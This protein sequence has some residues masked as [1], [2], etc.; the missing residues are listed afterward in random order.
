ME[1]QVFEFVKLGFKET[2][3]LLNKSLAE[4][5]RLQQKQQL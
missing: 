3:L 1:N 5:L 2:Q 4:C